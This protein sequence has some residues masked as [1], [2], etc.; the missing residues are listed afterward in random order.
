MSTNAEAGEPERRRATKREL[1]LLKA[2][3]RKLPGSQA[4]TPGCWYHETPHSKGVQQDVEAAAR[5]CS[6]QP[7]QSVR[8]QV[9]VVTRKNKRLR[10][11]ATSW[12]QGQCCGHCLLHC[13]RS[14]QC[15]TT[16][17]VKVVKTRHTLAAQDAAQVFDDAVLVSLTTRACVL[18]TPAVS[19]WSRALKHSHWIVLPKFTIAL[20]TSNMEIINV[21]FAPEAW[22][23]DTH[24]RV[25]LLL[26][27]HLPASYCPAHHR[28]RLR[29]CGSAST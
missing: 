5:W 20:T 25:C 1:A 17:T 16:E 24:L 23:V 14:T 19:L 7:C 6:G 4:L 12:I 26:M 2:A 27:A 28:W 18:Q 3:Q 21:C 11:L 13:C 8:D 9:Q 15:G 22:R 29:V 10:A